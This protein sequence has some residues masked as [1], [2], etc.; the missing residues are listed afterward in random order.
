M[1]S[2]RGRK[3]L[4]MVATVILPP[5]VAFKGNLGYPCH[6]APDTIARKLG[7][8]ICSRV[9]H[10]EDSTRDMMQSLQWLLKAMDVAKYLDF[11][12]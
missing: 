12:C 5:S 10:S 4:V 9:E 3:G 2:T 7:S 8:D 1:Y 11:L 6:R